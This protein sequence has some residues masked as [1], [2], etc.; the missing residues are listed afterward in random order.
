MTTLHTPPTQGSP[1]EPVAPPAPATTPSGPSG[2]AGIAEV[3]RRVGAWLVSKPDNRPRPLI[4][5]LLISIGYLAYEATRIAVKSNADEAMDNAAQLWRF[6]RV[7]HVDPE[8]VLNRALTGVSWLSQFAGYYYAT[9]H[10]IVTPTVLMWLYWRHADRYRWLRRTLFATTLPSLLIFWAVPLAPPRFAVGDI[11]DTLAE[12][13]ILGGLAPRGSE[14]VANLYAA[15]P[16]LHCAW[17]MWCALSVWFVFREKRPILAY[18]AWLYPVATSLDV[19]A[20]GNHYLLDIAG[21]GVM[22]GFGMVFATVS[23]RISGPVLRRRA[24]VDA[25]EARQGALSDVA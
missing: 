17:A 8:H 19:M 16:S 14:P 13:H 23:G 5:L 18:A 22:L 9:L 24:V 25:E 1:A 4:E 12:W 10:F 6:E 7:I 20:T 2:H 15:M 3:A 21:G 11:T